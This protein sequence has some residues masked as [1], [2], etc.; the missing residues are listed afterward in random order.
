MPDGAP[1]DSR[2]REI[3]GWLADGAPIR[4]YYDP[5][6]WDRLLPEI[7]REQARN[8]NKLLDGRWKTLED[9]RES[10]GY[11]RALQWLIDTAAV[12]TQI[13]PQEE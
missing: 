4:T 1:D 11:H 12:L 13:E 10:I 7:R 6:L 8:A 2:I 3:E 5:R 9:A